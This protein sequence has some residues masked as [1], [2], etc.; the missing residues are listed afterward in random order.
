MALNFSKINNEVVGYKLYPNEPEKMTL[1]TFGDVVRLTGWTH[2]VK[3]YSECCRRLENG[4]ANYDYII[5]YSKKSYG[6][7]SA[8]KR[9]SLLSPEI[10]IDFN[11]LNLIRENYGLQILA[12]AGLLPKHF[13]EDMSR[14][15]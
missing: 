15:L 10:I 6:D 9:M 3:T 13:L 12:E 14:T 11:S 5:D 4:L 2:R 7:E 8:A 1:M